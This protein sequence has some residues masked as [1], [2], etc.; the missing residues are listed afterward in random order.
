MCEEL[1]KGNRDRGYWHLRNKKRRKKR[2]RN[3]T[4]VETRIPPPNLSLYD[5]TGR[6]E[7]EHLLRQVRT[8]VSTSARSRRRETISSKEERELRWGDK[9]KGKEETGSE[10]PFFGYQAINTIGGKKR[11]TKRN[12]GKRG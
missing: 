4:E 11:F 8:E 12:H 1:R 6:M 2:G 7:R 5:S 3:V 10:A 9:I